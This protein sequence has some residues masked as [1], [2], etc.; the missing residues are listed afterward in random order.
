MYATDWFLKMNFNIFF[1]AV[2]NYMNLHVLEAFLVDWGLT[3]AVV[4][5]LWWVGNLC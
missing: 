1:L 2:E 3:L 4:L 5:E